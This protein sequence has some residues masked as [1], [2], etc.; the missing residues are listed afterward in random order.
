MAAMAAFAGALHSMAAPN[1]IARAQDGESVVVACGRVV[2]AR[3]VPL[4]DATLLVLFAEPTPE[5]SSRELDPCKVQPDGSFELLGEASARRV[6]VVASAPKCFTEIV[7]LSADPLPREIVLH[8]APAWRGRV[9][10]PPGIRAEDLAVR[11]QPA[12]SWMASGWPFVSTWCHP[13]TVVARRDLAGALDVLG[14]FE[15]AD[16]V[17]YHG[18]R[19]IDLTGFRWIGPPHRLWTDVATADARDGVV[20][21]GTIDLRGCVRTTRVHV[22]VAGCARDSAFVRADRVEHDIESAG[23]GLAIELVHVDE[24]DAW[25]G[26][27]DAR[28]QAVKLRGGEVHVV[29]DP[30]LPIEVRVAHARPLADDASLVVRFVDPM[31][32]RAGLRTVRCGRATFDANRIGTWSA[33][34]VAERGGVRLEGAPVSFEARDVARSQ[35]VECVLSEAQRALLAGG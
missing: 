28:T 4:P 27:P 22:T 15:R 17:E 6:T 30:V 11:I 21:L 26:A 8:R 9:V 16:G 10:L 35:P 3:G 33:V 29:L 34:L 20:E 32:R 13:G 25:V 12:R 19:H 1:A 7:E 23:D 5:R 14:R 31:G 2:D 24:V 18:T